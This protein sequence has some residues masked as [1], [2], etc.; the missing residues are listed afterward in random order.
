MH[1]GL[2]GE[3]PADYPRSTAQGL[4][5]ISAPDSWRNPHITTDPSR[6][7]SALRGK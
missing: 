2:I 3:A 1:D 6:I 5:T 4:P 7:P